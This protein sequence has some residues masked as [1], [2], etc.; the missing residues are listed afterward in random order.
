[1]FMLDST[2]VQI[3]WTMFANINI[4]V[5]Q[6]IIKATDNCSNL[7]TIYTLHHID[8]ESNI[9]LNSLQPGTEYCFQVYAK[10]SWGESNRTEALCTNTSLNEIS[11]T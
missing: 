8:L 4:P 3:N 1:M 7:P 6:V 10:N 11:G 2:S 5:D 9:V